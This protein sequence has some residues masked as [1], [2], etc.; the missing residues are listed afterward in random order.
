MTVVITPILYIFIDGENEVPIPCTI[1]S[2]SQSQ[3]MAE[4]GI[5]FSQIHYA[6]VS[7][8]SYS[9]LFRLE[10]SYTNV[11]INKELIRHFEK[12][13]SN[14]ST[15]ICPSHNTRHDSDWGRIFTSSTTANLTTQYPAEPHFL[16][17]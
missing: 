10:T 13:T 14:M 15:W 3:K 2:Q 12:C 17:L 8:N 11:M 4:P 5:K 1:C 6:T 16:H 9:I 7:G